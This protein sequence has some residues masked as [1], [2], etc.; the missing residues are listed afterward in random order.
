[1][2]KSR[3]VKRFDCLRRGKSA[4]LATVKFAILLLLAVSL[5]G[6]N[7]ASAQAAPAA[8]IEADTDWREDYAYLVG[9]QAYIY[10]LPGIPLYA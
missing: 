1:M 9:M 6:P 2:M 3:W 10:R 7:N 4:G 8:G 5:V